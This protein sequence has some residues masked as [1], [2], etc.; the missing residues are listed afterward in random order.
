M[1]RC[2]LHIGWHKTGTTALQD[3][4]YAHHE[5]LA[6]LGVVYPTPHPN[7][8]TFLPA[9][10]RGDSPPSYSEV[11]VPP[12]PGWADTPRREAARAVAEYW[13]ADVE[14]PTL[15]LS[16]EDLCLLDRTSIERCRDLLAPF[17]D[18]IT[19]VAYL[20]DHDSY[21]R[22]AVQQL[23]RMGYQL[24]EIVE[25]ATVDTI[26]TAVL[27][28]IPHYATRLADWA[29]VFGTESMQLFDYAAVVSSGESV[30]CHFLREVL[31]V[32]DQT[33]HA[34]ARDHPRSNSSCSWTAAYILN[35]MNTA[36]PLFVD[37]RPNPAFQ[38]NLQRFLRRL[39]GPTLRLPVDLV[40]PVRVARVRD[41]GD[42]RVP[43]LLQIDAVD[44]SDQTA[45]S[46]DQL[47]D[48]LGD[49]I[50]VAACE[51]ILGRARE[52][53]FAAL[54]QVS[55]HETR[56]QSI[57]QLHLALFLMADQRNL[58][59]SSNWLLAAGERGLASDYYAK[60][61]RFVARPPQLSRLANRLDAVVQIGENRP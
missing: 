46:G 47:L 14:Q 36:V 19:V 42:L 37:G 2:V 57:G 24:S 38:F 23:L 41:S 51:A 55:H 56:K 50:R 18:E 7:H 54:H 4:L 39:P 15:V 10:C 9:A 33:I 40:E 22:S 17:F 20:R 1:R 26:G 28:P 49:A 3:F 60:A 32:V 11:F 52:K 8:S 61:A 16:A 29:D 43:Q 6:K 59:S 44:L 35:R 45:L 53:F 13:L 12:L 5:D 34:A 48:D 58:I 31:G 30:Q 27:G 25:M 21:A